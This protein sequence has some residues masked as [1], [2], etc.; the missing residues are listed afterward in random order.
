MFIHRNLVII[1]IAKHGTYCFFAI[2]IDVLLVIH[3]L[4]VNFDYGLMLSRLTIKHLRE[5]H[6]RSC[7]DPY[8]C[9]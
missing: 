7:S 6:L 5:L 8:K 4:K 1:M 3:R 2:P 9:G